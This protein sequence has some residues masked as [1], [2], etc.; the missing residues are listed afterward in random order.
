MYVCEREMERKKEKKREREKKSPG[1]LWTMNLWGILLPLYP[2]MLG[3][4]MYQDFLDSQNSLNSWPSFHPLPVLG[5]QPCLSLPSVLQWSPGRPRTSYAAQAGFEL[6]IILP[7]PTALRSLLPPSLMCSISVFVQTGYCN[8]S[9]KFTTQS[10]EPRNGLIKAVGMWRSLS[11]KQFRSWVLSSKAGTEARGRSS[12]LAVSAFLS[13][14]F[15][16]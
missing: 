14:N 5:P 13:V 2:H 11:N 15:K 3:S 6:T 16:N 12:V 8:P 1:W 9:K 4:H 7:P 10:H